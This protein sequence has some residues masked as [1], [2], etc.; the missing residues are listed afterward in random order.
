MAKRKP[1]ITAKD[2]DAEFGGCKNDKE[3]IRKVTES[4]KSVS[5]AKA[6]GIFYGEEISQDVKNN[7]AVNVVTNI[8]VGNIYTGTVKLFDKDKLTFEIPGVKE[9]LIALDNFNTCSDAVT[10]YL[11]THENKL[12]F[13]VREKRDGKYYVSVTNAYYRIWKNQIEKAIE[14][15]DSITVHI[16]KLVNGGYTC[17]CDIWPLNEVTGKNFTNSVFIPGSHIVLNIER[18]FSKWLDKD[19]D[20]VPQKFV[21][22]KD[23]RRGITETS[24]V[25]SRKRVLQIDGMVKMFDIY[26]RA[27]L[28][29]MSN[30]KVAVKPEIFEGT[31]TGIIN[32]AKKTGVFIEL[33]GQNI[34]GLMPCE[35]D[36][37]C[38]WVP[39][40]SIKVS[41]AEFEIQEGKEPFI[42]NQKRGKVVKCNVRP[43]FKAA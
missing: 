7:R 19:V 9:E 26:N 30:A 42:V 24:L 34:T 43:V 3:R 35:A 16:D 41:I 6:F 36:E 32:S 40:D 2:F 29:T 14:R 23:W 8:T 31:V 5:L 18:D 38:N 1:L 37:L 11:L 27:K 39:G 21:D 4:Y 10:N 20:I 13:E 12:A 33:N 17:H 25:G 28:S 22:M 15:E